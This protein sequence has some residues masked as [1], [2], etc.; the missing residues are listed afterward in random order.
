MAVTTLIRE[1][2]NRRDEVIV[3]LAGYN[4][5]MKEF[6]KSNEGLKSRIPHWID[7]PD[8]SAEELT[9]IF[10]QMSA[11]RGFTVTEDAVK[12]AHFIFE[13]V[14]CTDNFGNGRY[15]R[16]LLDRAAQNQ[17][18]RLLPAGGDAS[19]IRRGRLFRI[20]TEDICMLEDGL[21]KERPSGTAQKEL[22]D[23]IGLMDVKK[24]IH[25]AIANYKRNKLCMD[26]GIL[27]DKA[28]L[29]MVFSGNPGTA[30]TTV[31]RLFAEILKEEKVLPTGNFVE[32]GRVDLVGDH[33]GMT[34]PLVKKRFREAQGG[35]LFI[36][37]AYALCDGYR[38]GYGDEA[39][40]TL[41]QEM[42][43]HREDVIVIFAGYPEPMK[44]F[45]DRNPGMSSRIAFQVSFD[46]Y[47]ADELCE[48]TKLLAKKKQLRLTDRAMDMLRENYRKIV[49][50]KDFGNGRYV[51]K[52][53]EEAEMNLAE[54]IMELEEDRLTSKLLTTID[55]CDIPEAVPQK[56]T[57]KHKIG[58]LRF[59]R[60]P[61]W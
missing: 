4:D 61:F 11:E 59:H 30:K 42:E 3:I 33:V 35:V 5:R 13:K 38:S 19:G 29:H 43:N 52:T 28:T 27:R 37:E 32:V 48:I 12:Q 51:R 17:A 25:K 10:R 55:A 53:L 41:V 57:G 14:R 60:L 58:F 23:L 47:S 39:I 22:D 20:E 26:R 2:E 6:M 21:R 49:K 16:N 18:A 34:A 1:M 50:S 36:D 24:V 44:E 45:L 40:N 9:D 54:R 7:F 15:V 8:Y 31:A 56:E 46:D